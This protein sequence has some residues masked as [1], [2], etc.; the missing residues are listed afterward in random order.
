MEEQNVNLNQDLKSN[1]LI[2]RVIGII[3]KPA[4]EWKKINSETPDI[5]QIIITYVLPLV[6]ISSVCTM[7]GLALIGK[8]TTVPFLG[9]FTSKSW[10][11]GI[12]TGLIQLISM[13]I[14][15]FIS[16]LVI[17][18]LA[19]SFKSEKNFGKSIQLVA[20]AFTPMMIGGILGIIPAISWIG[21]LFGL[22]GLYLLYLGL[23][24]MK[25]TPADQ[26]IAY[27]LVSLLI[28]IVAYVIIS[29][30]IG[31]IIGVF[32]VSSVLSSMPSYY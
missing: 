17:D 25:K 22:Y 26:T 28:I 27:F 18:L 24:P 14:S 13:I 16:A 15:I 32:F 9:S 1:S 12:S 7:L 3:T 6:I 2:T 19:N 23:N 20:Y 8:T 11:L 30:I 21:T 29:L 5:K 4:E 10:S 31:I